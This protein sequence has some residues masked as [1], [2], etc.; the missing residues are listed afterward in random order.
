MKWVLKEQ[1]PCS[2]SEAGSFHQPGVRKEPAWAPGPA[3]PP[4]VTDLLCPLPPGPA[5]AAGDPPPRP[6]DPPPVQPPLSHYH[7]SPREEAPQPPPPRATWGLLAWASWADS[8][9]GET[10]RGGVIRKE[11]KQQR[12]EPQVCARQYG[13]STTRIRGQGT[14]DLQEVAPGA[15]TGVVEG[16]R[17]GMGGEGNGMVGPCQSG[18]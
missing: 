3:S 14:G 5:V 10:W 18:C 2:Q 8:V 7:R 11:V 1:K 15:R 13:A 6:R 17:P 16:E 9:S 4:A 12:G